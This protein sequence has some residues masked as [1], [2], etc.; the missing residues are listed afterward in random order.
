[1]RRRCNPAAK[2]TR[3]LISRIK[4]SNNSVGAEAWANFTR[5]CRRVFSR[6]TKILRVAAFLFYRGYS[7][8]RRNRMI[9]FKRLARCVS[10]I[11]F[12]REQFRYRVSF[13][14]RKRVNGTRKSN[15]QD[16]VD[17]KINRP[18]D[19][20]A[21]RFSTTP[22]TVRVYRHILEALR[23]SNRSYILRNILKQT[24]LNSAVY[25]LSI[26]SVA[27]KRRVIGNHVQ[28][29]I[30]TRSR[31]AFRSL[32]SSV[33]LCTVPFAKTLNDYIGSAVF[34]HNYWY[35]TVIGS[36]KSLMRRSVH[37]SIVDEVT[38]RRT[39]YRH[40]IDVLARI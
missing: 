16:G 19:V 6:H 29:A 38:L 20:R 12:L 30:S 10:T 7:Q 32:V 1:M 40:V 9:Q 3:D 21:E 2:L 36:V 24:K 14:M 17:R 5:R 8:L 28:L 31:R 11:K 27:V 34:D 37:C 26:I 15:V 33:S 39:K 18:I 25:C 23:H 4:N 22:R 35:V 13:T